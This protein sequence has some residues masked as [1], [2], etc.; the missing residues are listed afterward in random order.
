MQYRLFEFV[1]GRRHA[2][3]G[4]YGFP[5]YPEVRLS[6]ENGILDSEAGEKLTH[7]DGVHRV[8]IFTPNPLSLEQAFTQCPTL[9]RINMFCSRSEHLASSVH[10]LNMLWTSSEHILNMFCTSSEHALN[11]FSTASEHLLYSFWTCSE[12][13]LN[14]FSTASEHVLNMFSTSY[15]F[16]KYRIGFFVENSGWG[17]DIAL[18]C[19]QLCPS[20]PSKRRR[21]N[22]PQ[23]QNS[24][25]SKDWKAR[26][27]PLLYLSSN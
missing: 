19:M 4:I 20:L 6:S 10:V 24:Y 16:I 17:F 8:H 15:R 12:H 27:R 18:Q 7:E 21:E 1:N 11:I 22:E 25:R 13:A 26:A 23:Q 3:L 14:I 9:Y 5:L 2:E